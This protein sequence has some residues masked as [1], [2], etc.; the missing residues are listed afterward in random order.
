MFCWKMNDEIQNLGNIQLT[1]FRNMESS[2]K[3][4]INK[5]IVT[6]AKKI[7]ERAKKVESL[8]IT[9][10]PVHK[11]EKGEIYEIHAKLVDNG[12][13]FASE[14]VDRNLFVAVDDAL[15]RIVS[16]MD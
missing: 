8:H 10:K 16:E 2:S 5:L 9:L 14:A 12:K 6:Y 3:D 11:R 13:V 1:G 4:V 7:S 15:K